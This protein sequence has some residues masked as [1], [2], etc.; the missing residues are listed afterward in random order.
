M[1]QKLF[2][3]VKM[4]ESHGDLPIYLTEQFLYAQCKSDEGIFVKRTGMI[5][6]MNG[7][8]RSGFICTCTTGRQNLYSPCQ[9]NNNNNNEINK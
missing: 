3:F 9:N 1:S 4:T 7:A 8:D 2:P 5:R 6:I